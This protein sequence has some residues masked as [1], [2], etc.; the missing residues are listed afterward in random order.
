LAAI[1]ATGRLRCLLGNLLRKLRE[2]LH[3]LLCGLL[4]LVNKL[5]ISCTCWNSNDL[6]DMKVVRINAGICIDNGLYAYPILICDPIKSIAL[7]NDIC[8]HEI[9]TS[10]SGYVLITVHVIDAA[11]AGRHMTPNC[12]IVRWQR[13]RCVPTK[14]E[15]PP[16]N[17][18][19][20]LCKKRIDLR[21]RMLY[22]ICRIS[23][24]HRRRD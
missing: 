13:M 7:L 1:W 23:V 2:L 22:T 24:R 20:C 8:Y 21:L 17:K 6:A 11:R 15:K 3:R 9:I 12:S 19:F 10:E 5:I 4:S 18:K 16:D 14:A